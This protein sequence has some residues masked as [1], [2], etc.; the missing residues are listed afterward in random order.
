MLVVEGFQKFAAIPFG[1]SRIFESPMPQQIGAN[2]RKNRSIQVK[3]SQEID[4]KM[5]QILRALRVLRGKI[6]IP[7][8]RGSLKFARSK[9]YEEFLEVQEF[10]DIL[11]LL[12]NPG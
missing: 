11:R 3:D 1:I 8:R 10:F 2:R 9:P 6:R 5:G 4:H 12:G 7:V